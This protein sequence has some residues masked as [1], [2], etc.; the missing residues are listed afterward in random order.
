MHT[1]LQSSM[2][3]AEMAT[4]M[5][6]SMSQLLMLMAGA[7]LSLLKHALSA[8]V[9]RRWHCWHHSLILAYGSIFSRIF[10]M[11]LWA[12]FFEA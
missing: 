12:G 11:C 5:V 8:S 3:C 9:G 6:K 10:S 1:T 7:T 4:R 2:D